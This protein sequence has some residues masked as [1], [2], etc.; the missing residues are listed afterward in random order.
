MVNTI[1]MMNTVA[2]WNNNAANADIANARYV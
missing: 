2:D 1:Q